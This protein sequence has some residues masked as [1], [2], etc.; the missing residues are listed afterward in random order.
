MK[1]LMISDSFYPFKGGVAEHLHHLSEALVKR[2]HDVTILT[3]N[4]PGAQD[5]SYPYR[6][7]RIGRI[8]ILPPLRIFNYTKLTITFFNPLKIR[9]F[10]KNN[11][12]DVVHVHGPL[13]FNL[14]EAVLHYSKSCN[15]ATFHTQYVGFNWNKVFRLFFGNES[16]N[17]HAAI[18]VSETARKTASVFRFRREFIIPNG[19]DLERF[20]PEGPQISWMREAGKPVV[21]FVGRLEKRKGLDVFLKAVNGLD[22][23]AVVVG[24]GPL[25]PGFDR[26]QVTFVGE[27]SPEELPLYYRSADIFVAPSIGG[28][29]FGIVLLEAMASGLPVIAS[30][31]EGY[32]N[33]VTHGKNGLLFETGNPNSL[34]NQLVE[35]LKK[36]SLK[37]ILIHEG[38]KTAKKFDWN[39]ISGK[40]EKVYKTCIKEG[41]DDKEKTFSR[42]S[43]KED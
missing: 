17:I 20:S 30:N 9:N 43:K 7:V 42:R 11:R 12:F 3:A 8:L 39:L 35:L 23:K 4:Y 19:V 18:F 31:I 38:L 37:N 41:K 26:H 5:E 6:V 28:E 32:R 15:I 40:I 36:P 21:L 2:G 24:D 29:T 1:I 10:L 14:P 16:K 13:T 25:K 27:V 34:K 33:V 22:V